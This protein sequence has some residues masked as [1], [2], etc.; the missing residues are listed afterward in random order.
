MS[1][2]G[3]VMEEVAA[4]SCCTPE[5]TALDAAKAMKSSGCG[6][7]PVVEDKQDLKLVGVVTA[8]D[9]SYHVAAEDRKA[10]EVTVKDIMKPVSACCKTGEALEEAAQKM[11]DHQAS[12]LPVMNKE[13]SCCGVVSSKHLRVETEEAPAASA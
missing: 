5:E 8:H 12:S 9:I 2:C 3:D 1:C 11:H 7:S 4:E 10:S 13:G 6:C